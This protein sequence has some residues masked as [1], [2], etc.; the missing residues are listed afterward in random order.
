MSTIKCYQFL[1]S[2]ILAIPVTWLLTFISGVQLIST[3]GVLFYSMACA[4]FVLAFM[5]IT[6]RK[7]LS[8]QGYHP[9][10]TGPGQD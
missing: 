7:S 6:Q 3:V 5:V 1:L 9:M 10:Y 4:L 2:I 8:R